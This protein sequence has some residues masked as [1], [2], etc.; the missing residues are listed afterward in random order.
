MWEGHDPL[1]LA[2]KEEEGA[3]SCGQPL[4]AG[5]GKDMASLL[6]FQ[7]GPRPADTPSLVLLPLLQAGAGAQGT[8]RS[9]V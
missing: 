5:K 4:E 7:E 2:L 1:L 8:K 3:T 6:A 9:L